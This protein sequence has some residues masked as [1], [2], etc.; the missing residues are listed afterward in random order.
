[1]QFQPALQGPDRRDGERILLPGSID[2]ELGKK[3]HGQ[4]EVEDEFRVWQFRGFIAP[5]TP[6]SLAWLRLRLLW[7]AGGKNSVRV[8]VQRIHCAI[9]VL[10]AQLEKSHDS[11]QSRTTGAIVNPE[12]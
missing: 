6:R 1:M 3:W 10:H 11:L 4:G 2:L 5:V 7:T 8:V 12:I 9:N